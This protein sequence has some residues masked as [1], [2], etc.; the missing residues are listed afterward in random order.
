MEY[1]GRDNLDIMH[2]AKNYNNYI[3]DWI[4]GSTYRE[5]LDFGA[6]NGEFCNRFDRNQV[7]AVE[8]DDTLRSQIDCESYSDIL[9]VQFKKFD[10][11]YSL[12]VLEHIEDDGFIV[13]SLHNLLEDSGEIKILVPAR[14]EIRTRMDDKVGHY[15]RYS[16]DSLMNLFIDNG[17]EVISCRYFDFLGY[18]AT[19]VYKLI[20]D[21]GDINPN[22]MKVY[23]RF[24]FPASNFLDKISFGKIIGKNLMLIARKKKIWK[25]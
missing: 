1:T 2:L 19:L 24:I 7:T 6:G 8:I 20:D 25:K 15:R 11:I 13:Q 22:S 10:L 12:N 16:K 3:F 4:D 9:D 21:S 17:F 14:E 18:F 5:V 23:D